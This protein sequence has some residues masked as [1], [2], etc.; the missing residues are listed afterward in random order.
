MQIEERFMVLTALFCCF[1]RKKSFALSSFRFK[2]SCTRKYNV[3]FLLFSQK[4]KK[5]EGKEGFKDRHRL[6]HFSPGCVTCKQAE[7]NLNIH[8]LF[9]EKSLANRKTERALDFLLHRRKSGWCIGANMLSMDLQ[10]ID[11]LLRNVISQLSSCCWSD[12]RGGFRPIC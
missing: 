12:S 8:Y 6:F 5:K 10:M 1:R 2:L 9:R 7:I 4:N 11:R 3:I